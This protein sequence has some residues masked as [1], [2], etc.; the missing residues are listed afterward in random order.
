MNFN[1]KVIVSKHA[2]ERME[3]RRQSMVD[4]K[5]KRYDRDKEFHIRCMVNINNI[6][7]ME[8]RP[9]GTTIVTT[10]NNYL[11][12]VNETKNANVITT[13]VKRGRKEL[14]VLV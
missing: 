9:N 11:V 2:M 5:Q 7:K 13:I 1:K 10:K 8:K 6:K 3:L 14:K 4:K 12:Y